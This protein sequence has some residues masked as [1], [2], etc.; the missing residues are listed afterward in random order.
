M[1]TKLVKNL[2]DNTWRKFSGMC[3][4]K[5]VIVG[6]ELTRILNSYLNKGGRI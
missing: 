1:V 6:E 4:M 2:N 3:K 5:G